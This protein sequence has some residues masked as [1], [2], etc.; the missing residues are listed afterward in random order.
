MNEYAIVYG[1]KKGLK[2]VQVLDVYQVLAESPEHAANKLVEEIGE[3]IDIFW[4]FS[5]QSLPVDWAEVK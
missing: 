1:T 2:S 4:V 3:N 5:G